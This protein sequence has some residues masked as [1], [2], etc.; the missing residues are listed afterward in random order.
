MSNAGEEFRKFS[1]LLSEELYQNGQNDLRHLYPTD[2]QIFTSAYFPF[3]TTF[4]ISN[5]SLV[6]QNQ[7]EIITP[8]LLLLQICKFSH[9]PSVWRRLSIRLQHIISVDLH[10]PTP[11]SYQIKSHLTPRGCLISHSAFKSHCAFA[12]Q[13]PLMLFFP[14]FFLFET[15][16]FSLL[17]SVEP[18]MLPLE[19]WSLSRKER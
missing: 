3:F 8:S 2:P 10:R 19:G 9:S 15:C 5:T 13:Q 1:I 12:S 11:L 16:V 6:S 18:Q 4:F 17:R 14:F 7:D